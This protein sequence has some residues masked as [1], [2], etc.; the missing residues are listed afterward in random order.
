MYP[1][2]TRAKTQE[3]SSNLV[4]G[5][6]PDIDG[7]VVWQGGGPELDLDEVAQLAEGAQKDWEKFIKSRSKSDLDKFE[8]QV[9]GRLHFALRDVPLGIVDDPGFWRYLSL[10]YFWWFVTWRHSPAFTRGDYGE[11]GKYI[12]GM[13]PTECILLR[14]Y[15]RGQIAFD[16]G[17]YVLADKIPHS[18]DF[19]RSHILRVRTG[20]SP[21]MARAFAKEQATK[22][23]STDPLRSCAKNLNRLWTNVVLYSYDGDEAEALIKDLRAQV[24]QS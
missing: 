15:L 3:L 24:E 11:F 9:A 7:A 16:N 5:G 22:K 6:E 12:D 8:G 13:Q 14:M 1:T 21:V 23:M 19:W 4:V 20:N 17:G 2:L 18:A 10:R